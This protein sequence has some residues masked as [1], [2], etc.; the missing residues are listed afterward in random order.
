MPSV[1]SKKKH[2]RVGLSAGSPVPYVLPEES[3][4][5]D[6]D[7]TQLK[8]SMLLDFTH[9]RIMKPENLE[10]MV[11]RLDQ[12]QENMTGLME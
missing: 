5:A 1:D 3:S 7:Q 9:G 10:Y 6:A 2:R 11:H 8:P 4:H 12:E